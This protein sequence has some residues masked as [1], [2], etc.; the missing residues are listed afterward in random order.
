MVAASVGKKQVGKGML[1]ILIA[2]VAVIAVIFFIGKLKGGAG[3]D[4]TDGSTE[5][6]RRAYLA[7]LGL[8]LADTSS[9]ADVGVPEEFDER[10]AQYNE[11]LKTNGFDLEPLRGKT[12]KKCTYTVTNRSDLALNVQAVLLVYDGS[13]VGGHLLDVDGGKLYALVDAAAQTI[14]PAAQEAADAG[15]GQEEIP[16]SAYPTE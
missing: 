12:V 7:S 13:I 15:A 16:A 6:L 3:G 9:V 10:F 1:L 4:Y 8:E 5:E 14:L 2:V 11:L